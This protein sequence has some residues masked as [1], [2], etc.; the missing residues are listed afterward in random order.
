MAGS[1]ADGG[2]LPPTAF[3]GP[4]FVAQAAGDDSRVPARLPGM[5]LG[6]PVPYTPAAPWQPPGIAGPWP[7]DEYVCDGGNAG[8]P[9]R[10]GR[11]YDVHGLGV[12]DTVAHFDTLEGQTLVEPS[13]RVCLYSPRF[14]AVR[15]VVGVEI[16]Q[17][18]DR[19][20]DV[21]LPS[22]LAA[23]TTSQQLG[24]SGQKVQP[25]AGLGMHPAEALRMRQGDGALSSRIG[26][27]GF[28]N[29][30]RSYENVAVIRQGIFIEAEA[31]FL[32]KGV[33]AA[34]AWSHDQAVQIILDHQAANALAST[35]KLQETYTVGSLP[36]QPRLRLVKVASTPFAEPGDEVAFTL[37]FDNVG[38]QPIGNVTILDSLSGRLEYV[39]GSAQCSRKAQ[40]ST[41]PNEGDSVLVR[42][43]LSDPLP[44]GA[45]GVL[46]FSCRVR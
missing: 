14:G 22:R 3:S 24:L 9:V 16:D 2:T 45:G 35:R 28:D 40:F 7:P 13:N 23:P 15:Q 20:T 27:N 26:P 41:R 6:V 5:E 1:P 29:A 46:R 43:E 12:E 17:Q 10:V 19:A 4:G 37:R 38:N 32:A 21:H 31:P 44:P 11:Q 25:V 33:Q 30:Y 39:A 34:V 8:P 36:A 18:R 42:C